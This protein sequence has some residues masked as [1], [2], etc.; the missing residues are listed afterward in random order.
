MKKAVCGLLVVGDLILSVSRKDDQ[1]KFGF[2]GG[3]LDPGEDAEI[4]LIR[5]Y[6]EE[7]GLHISIDKNVKE[8]V[9]MCGEY[10]TVTYVVKL[11]QYQTWQ[12]LDKKETGLVKLCTKDE[13]IKGPFGKY[14]IEAFQY[15]NL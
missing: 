7:T 3:K 14:N 15:F 12:S 1:T 13:L 9:S 2:V 8:F 6:L 10:H 4:A 5:E 11:D